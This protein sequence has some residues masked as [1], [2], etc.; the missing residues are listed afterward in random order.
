MTGMTLRRIACRN[1]TTGQAG[2]AVVAGGTT[3]WTCGDLGVEADP[4][5]RVLLNGAGAA[6]GSSGVGGTVE[7]L[8]P[9]TLRRISCRNLTTAQTV[10]LVTGADSWDCEAEGLVVTPGDRV[11]QTITGEV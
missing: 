11:E 7:A 9:S 10:E 3:E 5:D 2:G 8:S 6:D 4:S 1:L